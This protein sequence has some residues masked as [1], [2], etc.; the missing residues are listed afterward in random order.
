MSII[1]VFFLFI[2]TSC[3]LFGQN[4][5][6]SIELVK[7]KKLVQKEE[8]I[9]KAYKEYIKFKGEKPVSIDD[10]IEA[11]YLTNFDK[12]NP[13]TGV[14]IQ[15]VSENDKLVGNVH[16]E[17]IS[18]SF[19]YDYY[20]SSSNRIYTKPPL[21][22]QAEVLYIVLSF[23]E[24]Y[25]LNHTSKITTK[26][27][28]RSN[29]FYLDG[30]GILHW[31]DSSGN[32]KLSLGKDLIIDESIPLFDVDGNVSSEFKSLV[33]PLGIL[34]A[35]QVI[36]H[37]EQGSAKE[38]L[39]L[40]DLGGI[41]KI[42]VSFKNIGKT[43]IQFNKTSGGALING[44]IYTW[45]N[46]A[47]RIATINLDSYT[48]ENSSSSNTSKYPVITSLVRSKVRTYD[49][50]YNE[51]DIDL[52]S[53]NYY[54]SPIRPK[55][56]DLFSSVHH[57]TCGV[58]TKGE[59][60]CGGSTGHDDSALF[61][62]V[63][64]IVNKEVL[65]RSKFFDGSSGKKAVKVLAM[66]GLWLILANAN[67]DVDGGYRDGQ[68][69]RW[70]KDY[71][72]FSGVIVNGKANYNNMGNP[73]ELKVVD[74]SS[75]VLFKDLTYLKN[76]GENS[77]RKVGALSNEGDIWIWGLDDYYQEKC[78]HKIQNQQINLCTPHKVISDVS[79]VSIQSGVKGFVAK[80]KDG[81]YYR[82]Q[83]KWN[84][85]PIVTLLNDLI[86]TYSDYIEADDSEIVAIDLSNKLAGSSDGIV[87]VNGKHELKG[88]YV[89]S[90]NSSDATFTT[91]VSKIKWKTIK[92]LD[93]KNATCGIDI[94]NQM[95]CWGIMSSQKEGSLDENKVANTFMIPV[96]NTNL[97]DLD[98]DYLVVEGGDSGYLTNMTS[99]EWN[100]N[101]TFYLK[102]PTYIGG[103]NYEF[104]FK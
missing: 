21:S 47:N 35:G 96:F 87:W 58:S 46:N 29:K 63:T 36:L 23:Y 85:L 73:T 104:T 50:K 82:I 92:V 59:L 33:E 11:G 99:E 38:Y 1:K 69:Y 20:F 3:F 65:Y 34:Y 48:K 66:N 5:M 101:G 78:K 76:E 9:A 18:K 42:G 89:T 62:N 68:I 25:I 84:E 80:G 79:F 24:K 40:G 61:K 4:Y 53:D 81:N 6:D 75:K 12:T 45:G 88:D 43:I 70:G 52:N 98:K 22:K 94:N 54:A 93:E 51:N 16:K 31:Y 39:Y 95:Y 7:I 90:A 13:F 17:I 26:Y 10:I 28:Q 2:V 77:Y 97:F 8:L 100:D 60:Y 72:G 49:I 27:N 41:I 30:D 83:Q 15:L 56:I 19:L 37:I 44:D 103:F 14:N 57:S 86:K 55:F 91:T 64:T 32:Y 74:N 71:A 102:Y 67:N